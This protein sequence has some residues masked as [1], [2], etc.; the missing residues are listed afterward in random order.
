[1][2]HRSTEEIV[3]RVMPLIEHF[4]L[5]TVDKALLLQYLSARAG[6]D[7]GT[8]ILIEEAYE[9]TP[10][11]DEPRLVL[12][13]RDRLSGEIQR[14]RRPDCLPRDLDIPVLEE[15]K[16]LAINNN[17]A[18]MNRLLFDY[19]YGESHC[20]L[21]EYQGDEYEQFH[22]ECHYAGKPVNFSRRQI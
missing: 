1:M 19:L 11:H 13:L 3:R 5:L 7:W 12:V 4:A 9:E 18:A 22:R 14:I 20:Q 17:L 10:F 16:R 6:I 15:Y 2:V 21:C 8:L